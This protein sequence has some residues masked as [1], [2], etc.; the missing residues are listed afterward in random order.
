MSLSQGAPSGA[1]RFRPGSA[2][3]E[4]HR[5]DAK[6]CAKTDVGRQRD[7]NEDAFLVEGSCDLFAVFDGMG[8]NNAGE[9]ASALGTRSLRNFFQATKNEPAH[10]DDTDLDLSEDARRL[11]TGIRKANADIFEISSTH[12]EH[13]GMGSTVVALHLGRD[14]LAHIAH[15]GDS[16]CYRVRDGV[17][18]Q[19]TRDHSLISDALAWNPNLTKEELSRLPRN[20]ISRALGLRR[21]VEIDLLSEPM[22]RGDLFLLCSDGLSG[23]LSDE[24]IL[25]LVRLSDDL[26]ETCD[27]LIALANEAGGNDNITALVI[28]VVGD[29]AQ[30]ANRVGV[31]RSTAPASPPDEDVFTSDSS[32]QTAVFVLCP[33][34]GGEPPVDDV[35]CS[36]CGARLAQ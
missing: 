34:C 20:I 6:S 36:Q 17:I 13:R 16:R 35:F 25:E 9:V 27:N 11:V 5:T 4:R 28:R 19:L 8:G 10:W 30:P 29:P 31:G 21:G 18:E 33:F 15:V 2:A 32:I 22:Q 26:P 12:L 23:M 14:G 24:Q 7:H 3:T 1:H